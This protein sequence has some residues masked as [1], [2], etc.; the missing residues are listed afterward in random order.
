[1]AGLR[2][3]KLSQIRP[4]KFASAVVRDFVLTTRFAFTLREVSKD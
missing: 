2:H 3:M 1:M 4:L